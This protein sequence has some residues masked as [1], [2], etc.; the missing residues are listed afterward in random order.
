MA[1]FVA[2][3]YVLGGRLLLLD[4]NL[5]VNGVA[6]SKNAMVELFFN[7]AIGAIVIVLPHFLEPASESEKYA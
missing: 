6:E 2:P 1:C 4:V 3:G 5:V 7:F